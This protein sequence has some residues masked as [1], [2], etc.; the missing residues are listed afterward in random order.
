MKKG[1]VGKFYKIL[2]KQGVLLTPE[3]LKSYSYDGTT[4]WIHEPDVVLLPTSTHQVSDIL[5]LANEER[6]PVTP[7]GG[8]TNV[9]GGSIPIQGGIVLC[10]TRMNNIVRVDKEN[11]SATVESGA[12]LQD[13]M[14]RF[15]QDGL[16]FPPDPQSFLGANPGRSHCRECRWT[17]V[18]K[19]R[20]DQ[21]IHFGS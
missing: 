16:F 2:G 7:R 17:I 13:L 9:S 11:L 3:G 15:A 5:R 14:T 8:G 20:C 6:I 12:V 21:A 1:V 18:L 4:N 19:I 10:M